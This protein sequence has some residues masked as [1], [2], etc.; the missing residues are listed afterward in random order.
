MPSTIRRLEPGGKGFW[1]ED[2]NRMARVVE[3]V[4][5]LSIAGGSFSMGSSGLSLAIPEAPELHIAKAG[6]TDAGYPTFDNDRK[7]FPCITY[8]SPSFDPANPTDPFTFNLENSPEVQVYNLAECWIFEDS[9]LLL[10]KADGNYW[11][12]NNQKRSGVASAGITKGNLGS[13]VVLGITIQARA[14]FADTA[15][16]AAVSVYHDG[17]EWVI[18]AEE[19]P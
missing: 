13:V 9:F 19:C 10:L 11:T 14:K 7:V 8:A 17:T 12:W 16:G 4:E 6:Q 15:S 2:Y 18:D 5:R 3:L 1:A